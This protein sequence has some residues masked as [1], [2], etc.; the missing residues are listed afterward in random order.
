VDEEAGAAPQPSVITGIQEREHT[1]EWAH[2][3]LDHD[4]VIRVVKYKL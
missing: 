4:E 3:I 1:C 2:I